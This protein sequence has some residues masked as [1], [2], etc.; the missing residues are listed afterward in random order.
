MMPRAC[1]RPCAKTAPALSSLADET[2]KRTIRYDQQRSRDRH[3]IEHAFCRLKDFR[4]IATCYNTLAANL[5]PDV[6]LTTA[7]AFWLGMRLDP[8]TTLADICGSF[9]AIVYG[10]V[11]RS[12]VEVG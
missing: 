6:A 8:S 10:N 3:L 9:F 12:A 2:E 1:A 4:R 7:V 5:L 11:S